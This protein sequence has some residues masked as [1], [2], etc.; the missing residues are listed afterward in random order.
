MP[1]AMA[2]KGAHHDAGRN[3]ERRRHSENDQRNGLHIDPHQDRRIAVLRDGPYGLTCFGLLHEE[4]HRA[5][6]Q[7]DGGDDHVKPQLRDRNAANP[8]KKPG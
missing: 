5:G 4:H 1:A 2:N 8:E 7:Q 3:P 6:H